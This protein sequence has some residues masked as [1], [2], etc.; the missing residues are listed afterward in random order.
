[1]FLPYYRMSIRKRAQWSQESLDKALQSVRGGASI[2]AASRT[3]NIPRTTLGLH[4]RTE[5]FNKCLGR[6]TVLTPDQENDLVARIHRLADVG[7]PVTSRIVRRSVFAYVTERNL[8]HPF[9]EI[10]KLAGRKWLALFLKRHP[11]VRRR[12][13][14][15]MNPARAQKMNSF[16]VGDYF[17]KL[18]A[19][20]TKLKLFDKPG[21]I[22]NMDEKGCRLTIHK[23]QLVLAKKGAKR[24]HLTAP[25]HGENVSIVGCGN[26]LGQAIPP[27]ILFKG[28]RQKPEWSDH[29]PAGSEI[30][31]TQKGSMTNDAFISWLSHFAKYKNSG[32]TLLIFDGAKSH[33]DI[34]IVEAAESYEITLLCLPSNTTHELQPMDKAVF[35]SFESFWDQ[36]VLDFLLTQPGKALTKTR[37]GEIFTRVWLKAMTPL[38]ITSGFR[39]TG[40]YPF[41]PDIIP[42][43]AFAPSLITA[44]DPSENVENK[45]SNPNGILVENDAV[46]STSRQDMENNVNSVSNNL[47][48]KTKSTQR[49]KKPL[50]MKDSTSYSDSTSESNYSV[51]DTSSDDLSSLLSDTEDQEKKFLSDS[52]DHTPAEKDISFKDVGLLVTPEVKVAN[53]NRRPAINSRAQEVTRDLFCSSTPKPLA[54]DKRRIPV[55]KSQLKLKN[56]ISGEK[57]DESWYC[58]LCMEDRKIDMRIC[59]QCNSY[60]HEECAGLSKK[61]KE[62][63]IC[64]NCA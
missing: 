4:Y 39:A 40:I 55:S 46:P 31:M 19:T 27:F 7:M 53:T 23:Q 38:N 1:M 10:N 62:M 37:F 29:L 34:R 44:K 58:F 22:Y 59:I 43:S 42:E 30:M 25:E 36:E 8:S 41:R 15:Q 32:P 21:N 11:E 35:R 63:F 51:H 20:L 28:K 26:A 64:P 12:R 60:V 9:S 13:A 5:N 61:D 33:L 49:N 17:T 54:T 2:S 52:I 14:Q 50:Q 16:I 47:V 18:K 57:A 48:S 3:Y 45:G 24:V 56:K 6:K